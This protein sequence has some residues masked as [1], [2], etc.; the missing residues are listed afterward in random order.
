MF[1]SLALDMAP[2]TGWFS[3]VPLAG[4]EFSPGKR[5]DVWSQI[6][7]LS[8]TAALVGAVE[9]LVTVFKQ[10][11]VGMALH[12][13]PIYVWAMVVTAFMIIFAM[14][15]VMIGSTFVSMDRLANVNTHF[16]NPAEGGDA[17]LYQHIFWFFGHPEVYIIFIPATGF[18]STIVSTFSG[19]P[20]F[21]YLALVLA[22]IATGFMAFGLWVHHMF[23]TPLP[24]LGE[25]FFS[26]A[27]MMIALPAGVQV[28]CWIATL[29]KGRPSFATPLL[30]VCGFIALFTIGGLTGVMLASVPFDLQAHDTYFV[31]AHFHYVLIGAA[32]FP[33]FGALYYWFPKATGRLLSE[34]VGR[35]N[36]WLF[37]IGFNVTFFPMHILGLRGMPRRVYTYAAETGWGNLNLLA[38]IGAFLIGVSVLIFLGNVAWSLRRGKIADANPWNAS[39]LEWAVVSPPPCYN[40]F[41][42]P[43]VA[44]ADPLWRLPQEQPVI[45]GLEEKHREVLTTTILEAAP[46]HRYALATDSIFPGLLALVVAACFTS[47]IFTAWAIPVGAAFAFLVLLGWFWRGT[48]PQPVSDAAKPKREVAA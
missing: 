29:W 25:S 21:G 11:A 23:A 27:S 32:V 9:I 31:V 48:E 19:R 26:A 46:D 1:T 17:L 10:R 15:A 8:E 22:L 12:R 40:F 14:P 42:P 36:F 39:T 33:L 4:P 43:T 20:V 2:D 41:H 38:T 30:F 34:R 28:F 45:V 37:F 13:I 24:E 6:I 35:W 7:T 3:Y 18:V 44:S 47:V 16:F 5:V